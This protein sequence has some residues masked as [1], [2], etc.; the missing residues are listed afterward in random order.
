[1]RVRM[2]VEVE[3]RRNIL[4]TGNERTVTDQKKITENKKIERQLFTINFRQLNT[5]AHKLF[6]NNKIQN[7]SEQ[8]KIRNTNK[9]N[10]FVHHE[11]WCAM[12]PPSTR[13][14]LDVKR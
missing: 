8:I 5:Q 6:E 4:S 7:K 1:M 13:R 11:I 2:R 12:K 3:A 14:R 10:I 9:L